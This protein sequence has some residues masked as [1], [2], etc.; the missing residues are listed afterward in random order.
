MGLLRVILALAVVATHASP[1]LPFDIISGSLAVEA[2]YIISGFYMALILNEKYSHSYWLFITNRILRIYP[3]YLLVA[4][5]TVIFYI[6]VF[7][8]HPNA[9]QIFAPFAEYASQGGW[10]FLILLFSNIFILGLDV[11]IFLKGSDIAVCFL[12]P[13]AW[14]LSL[15]MMFYFIAPFLVRLKMI[16]LA[17]LLAISLLLRLFLVNRG[18][19]QDPWRYYFFPTELAFFILGIFSYKIYQ[20]IQNRHIP[21]MINMSIFI[22][23]V[24]ATIFL[25]VLK[26]S[27]L[28]K[29]IV[30]FLLFS[31]G[32]PFVFYLT[33]HHRFD[34]WIGEFSYTIYLTH[35][36][37]IMVLD[38]FLKVLKSGDPFYSWWVILGSFSLSF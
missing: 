6:I 16:H 25:A 31:G 17:F 19:D 8:A 24:A 10:I 15:E 37:V 34:R 13:Q 33:R 9:H 5:L 7:L 12:V 23:V 30:Y 35:V 1:I 38:G 32:L 21:F 18:F 11:L 36:L 20:Q 27:I 4:G 28:A 22:L 2:F 26:F 14:T 29:S 3:L